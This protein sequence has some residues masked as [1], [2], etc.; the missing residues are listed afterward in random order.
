MA[1]NCLI[2]LVILLVFT[3]SLFARESTEQLAGKLLEGQKKFEFL[4]QQ[5]ENKITRIMNDATL[6]PRARQYAIRSLQEDFLKSSREIH[7]KYREPFVQRVIA[8]TN[9]RLPDGKT[10][11]KGLGSDIY[12][13]HEVTGKV[14]KDS[15]GKRVLNPKHRGWQGDLDLGGNPRAVEELNK[16]F[17]HY[18]VN[19]SSNSPHRGSSG[20][21]GNRWLLCDRGHQGRIKACWIIKTR[22]NCQ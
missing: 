13:R 19:L 4:K 3:A 16:T 7:L 6:R 18:G 20:G 9:A 17:N 8:E 12:L 21:D 11:K 2:T 15:R 14:V 22:R 10:I 5:R 1:K